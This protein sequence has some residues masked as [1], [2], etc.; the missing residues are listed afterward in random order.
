MSRVSEM[1]SLIVA[2][3]L[4]GTASQYSP[5]LMEKVVARQQSYGNLPEDLPA[6]DG[7]IAV[8]D[9]REVG[10]I[11][12]VRPVGDGRWN[13]VM[14]AD[15]SGHTE[16]SS[17]MKRNNIPMELGWP[18]VEAFG[19]ERGKGIRVEYVRFDPRILM[20]MGGVAE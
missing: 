12:G 14:V 16:T 15:C 10:E 7:F 3:F 4:V 1:Q 18:L 13:R 20:G 2:L 6:V 19:G 11:W 17:W 9:C 8:E 5:F